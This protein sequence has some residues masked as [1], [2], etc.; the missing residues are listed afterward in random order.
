MSEL[1]ELPSIEV[2]SKSFLGCITDINKELTETCES[3]NRLNDKKSNLKKQLE[4]FQD[5]IS[6]HKKEDSNSKPQLLRATVKVD[7][8]GHEDDKDSRNVTHI[9]QLNIEGTPKF[10]DM[11]DFTGYRCYS[12]VFV[13]KNGKIERAN[14]SIGHMG[15]CERGVTVPLNI[16]KYLKEPVKKYSNLSELTGNFHYITGYELNYEDKLVQDYVKH[17]YEVPLNCRYVYMCDASSIEDWTL[18]AYDHED[19]EIKIE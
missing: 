10:G 5:L 18:Y 16:C 3:I 1:V 13:G 4:S 19:N 2:L 8:D 7:P 15:D 11:L 9:N 14:S 12:W 6:M 17:G